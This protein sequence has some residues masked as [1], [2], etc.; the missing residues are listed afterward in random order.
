MPLP[1]SRNL[2]LTSAS[3]F[4]SSL[5]NSLQDMI[6]GF[7]RPALYRWINPI[8][9]NFE[10][11]AG[12]LSEDGYLMSAA[13]TWQGMP[14]G[15]WDEG[16]R[17]TAFAVKHLG[18]GGAWTATYL[19]RMNTG[20]GTP[21]T[22]ATLSFVNPPATWATYAVTL[23]TPQVLPAGAGLYLSQSAGSP[24]GN[25]LGLIGIQSDRL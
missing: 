2:T 5:G 6:V 16:T 17:I 13:E 7:K 10:S 12:T 20:N 15:L 24:V 3:A 11:V 21:V 25:K 9:P 8:R 18:T 14:V 22:I 4:P 23:G 19:L 1:T